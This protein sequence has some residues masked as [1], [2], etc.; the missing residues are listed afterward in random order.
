MLEESAL[1]T[2][3]PPLTK[4]KPDGTTY[5]RRGDVEDALERLLGLPRSDVIAS[6]KIRDA[7]SALYLQS[8]CIVHLIRATRHDNNQ[9]YF[10]ELYRELMR[11][12]AAVLPRVEGERAGASENVHAA[13]ARDRVRD[14]FN[15]KLTVD[16]PEAGSGLDYFEVMFAD[17]IAA[18]RKTAMKRATR[19]AA[20]SERIGAD[21]DSS[22]P[23]LVV[24]R[25]VGSL[26]LKQELLSENPTYRSR[27]IAAIQALPDKQRR[28]IEMILQEM[29]I[30]SSDE[31][32]VT[33]RKMIGVS[34]EK[35]VRN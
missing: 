23:S 29:P 2:T 15:E 21:D 12:I 35:T 6:L 18:L 14:L 13:D 10:G 11:R 19:S 3:V 24:E 25:A 9:T 32:V 27:V 16:R 33:I 34:S 17:A 20:R 8:E 28:V 4:Q 26:D 7:R 5:T 1:G 22:E 31:S 30:D